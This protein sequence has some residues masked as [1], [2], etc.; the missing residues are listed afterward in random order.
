MVL[1]YELCLQLVRFL[2]IRNLSQSYHDIA[3]FMYDLYL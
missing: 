3:A 2:H 1:A